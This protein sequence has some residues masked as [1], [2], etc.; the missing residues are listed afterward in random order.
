M[1]LKSFLSKGLVVLVL[2]TCTNMLPITSASAIPYDYTVTGT[3]TGT[4]NADLTVSGGSFN[5]WSLTTPTATFTNLT[6]TT[7]YNDNFSLLQLLGINT[8]TFVILPPPSSDD[9]IGVYSGKGA[10]GVFSGSFSRVG[11]VP[12]PSALLL[13]GFA[14][15]G[16]AVW[17]RKITC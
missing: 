5:S 4:F 12:E 9:Y 2:G 14:L 15:V 16:L 13:L 1:T 3:V 17:R 10:A 11:S 6:G 8:L 7:L